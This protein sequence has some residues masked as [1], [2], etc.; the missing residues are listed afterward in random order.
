M[1]IKRYTADADTTITNAYKANLEIRGTGS[2][3]GQSDILE[4]FSIFAQANISSSELE[5]ILIKFPASASSAGN[6]SYDRS[7]GNIPASGSVSF[8]LR[9]FSAKHSQTT[10]KDFNLIIS[11]VSQSWTE[12]LGLDMEE[13]S[14]LGVANWIN[15]TDTKIQASASVHFVAIGPAADQTITLTGSS[16]NYIF[17]ATGSFDPWA[18]NSFL[19]GGTPDDMASNFKTLIINSASSDFSA[20][21]AECY[22]NNRCVTIYAATAGAT[23]NT[24]ALTSS[25]AG[26]A[27]VTGSQTGVNA[28]FAGGA[29]ATSWTTEGGDYLTD[30]SS[31]FTASFDTGFENID[32][33]ITPL[34]EQWI[35]DTKSNYG[36]GVRL[37]ATEDSATDS[38]YT[39]MFFAR[40]SQF[41]FKRPYIEARWDSSKK[42]D[43]GSFYYSSSLAPA[44]DNLNTI[45]L[46]NYVRGQLK[47]IPAIGTGSI[48]VSIYSGSSANSAPSGS[49]LALS[50]G[51]G[52]ASATDTN[53]TGSYVSTGIYSASFAFT[54]STSLTRVFDVWHSSSVQYFTGT[55]NPKS[56]TQGWPGQ[57][58]N[59]NQQYVSKISNLKPIYSNANTIARFRLYT[60]KKDW[61]PNIY[62]V[63]SV[64]APIDLVEDA[65]YRVYRIDDSSDVISYGTGSNNST[66]LSFDVS[67]SYFDLDMSLLEADNTY[68]IKF[69]Y[70]LNNQYSEQSEEFKF[71][72]ESV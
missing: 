63:A 29:D 2:N 26:F 56:L 12:G 58:F 50:A 65:Y 10:P 11:A 7:Q 55:I 43:R 6:I 22:G 3:M 36:V 18:A 16:A 33:N 32:L 20:S 23:A 48:L 37:S 51:G 14:D 68:A 17:T 31:S 38:Y 53:V 42:D 21:V 25:L 19:I 28:L 8:Y 1:A 4:V 46:Y 9:M 24:N 70:Y 61:S 67:G 47:N 15:A 27:T 62:T 72:V 60:R 5:R 57:A 39:K 44:A 59:P 41:F 64:A 45:Y 30:S 71:K 40:G 66:R 54:G 13:Y 35:S 49:K 52:V 34:V 69:V